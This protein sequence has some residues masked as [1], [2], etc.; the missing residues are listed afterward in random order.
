MYKIYYTPESEDNISE[1]F[2]YISEDNTFYAIKV[3]TKLKS[4]IDILKIFPLAWKVIWSNRMI[5]ES[6]Y[7]FNIVYKFKWNSVYIL[8]I[9]RYRNLLK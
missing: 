9:F 3:I 4:T 2:S 8:S 7:K 1:I 5:V 6:N